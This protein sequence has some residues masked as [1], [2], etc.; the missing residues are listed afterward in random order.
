LNRPSFLHLLPDKIKSGQPYANTWN[1]P[2]DFYR[3]N[4]GYSTKSTAL[5]Q[6]KENEYY[7]QNTAFNFFLNLL[8]E[9]L[10]ITNKNK[11]FT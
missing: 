4:V 5:K 7:T 9:K 6:E 1:L 11:R 10:F 3:L 8:N 2:T